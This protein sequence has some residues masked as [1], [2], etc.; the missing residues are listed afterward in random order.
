[1]KKAIAAPLL[2]TLTLL[3]GCGEPTAVIETP[4]HPE[5][6]A[7]TVK[8]PAESPGAVT[9]T[10]RIAAVGDGNRLLIPDF[11]SNTVFE[12]PAGENVVFL[13]DGEPLDTEISVDWAPKPG[14]LAEIT[15]DGFILD[16]WPCQ[17]D[18]VTTVNILSEGVNDRCGLYLGM[19]ED[20][21]KVDPGLNSEDGLEYLGMD[22][23]GLAHLTESE[24]AAVAFWFAEKHGL[25][26]LENTWEG[27][28]DAGYIDKDNLVWED[29][30]F[31]SVA[32]DEDALWSLPGI[33]EE[34]EEQ[35]RNELLRL[36][37][38]PPNMLSKTVFSAQKW[39][40][41]TGAYY[42]N[43]CEARRLEDGSWTYT[44]GSE[45]IS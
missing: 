34:F 18:N 37:E 25:T 29:G 32:T 17:L 38:T 6:D 33:E 13:V 20:L 31:I 5:E 2:L 15:Y 19:L 30:I 43:E 14:A 28:C 8:T 23:S 3:A 24:Q 12:V 7:V 41:G 26:L 10:F 27:L 4:N 11:S 42:F 21:W 35:D 40:S 1:M 22:L 39:R 9:G 16:P 36:N 45:A 44:V